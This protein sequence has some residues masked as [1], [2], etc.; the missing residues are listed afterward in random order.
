[1]TSK[2]N[3]RTLRWKELYN[4]ALLESNST[5]L[6]PLLNEAI[7]IVLDRIEET[8][9]LAELDELNVALNCLRSR[10]KAIRP[11]GSG[12]SESFDPNKAA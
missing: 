1:M 4:E 11:L 6:R 9:T 5:R 2:D 12:R 8:V 3:M 7:N 10:R